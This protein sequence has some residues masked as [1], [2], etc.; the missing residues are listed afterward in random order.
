MAKIFPILMKIINLQIHEAQ[1]TPSKEHEGNCLRTHYPHYPVAQNQTEKM[2][3]Y[4]PD[5]I[6]LTGEKY[7]DDSGATFLK[8]WKKKKSLSS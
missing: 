4:V 1:W 8:Y 6:F 7:E 5:S 3:H 2:T